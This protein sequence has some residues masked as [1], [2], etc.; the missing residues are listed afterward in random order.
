MTRRRLPPVTHTHALFADQSQSILDNLLALLGQS[1]V[2]NCSDPERS[3]LQYE[4]ARGRMKRGPGNVRY[5]GQ[6][7][8]H[9]LTRSFTTPDP[10]R[11]SPEIRTNRRKL[12]PKGLAFRPKLS[13]MPV[14][15]TSPLIETRPRSAPAPP[16]V[17]RAAQRNASVG[18]EWC[19]SLSGGIERR[20]RAFRR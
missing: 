1:S 10:N 17:R 15:R 5:L 11:K 14:S 20:R 8:E 6:F 19:R 12:M 4:W 3:D 16:L 2:W 9:I 18:G 7:G 13:L